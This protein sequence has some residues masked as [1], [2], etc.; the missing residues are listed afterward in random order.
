MSTTFLGPE[1]WPALTKAIRQCHAPCA[2]AVASFAQGAATLLPLSQGSRLVVD[3]SERA[4]ASGQTCPRDL[5]VLLR[6]GVTIYTVPNLHAKLFVLPRAAYVGSA[7]ASRHS[8]G[9]LLEALLRTTDPAAVRSA[10]EFVRSLCLHQ[11]T[12]TTLRTLSRLYRPPRVPGGGTRRKPPA[13]G[14]ATPDLPVLRLVQLRPKAWSEAQQQLH[15]K[16]LPQARDRRK[17]TRGYR[18]ESFIWS[19]KCAIARGE[20]LLQ[21]MAQ[22]AGRKTVSPPGEV[23]HTRSR[24][25]PSG[26]TTA[27]YVECPDQP[28]R[29]LSALTRQLG[30]AAKKRLNRSGVIRDQLLAQKLLNLWT[31]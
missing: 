26:Q 18:T 19:G 17:H 25:L 5:L 15:D 30:S 20:L 16:G 1:V 14:R 9:R 23:I 11:L 13:P 7:N 12:P 2:V 4:V 24:R 21:L 31:R 6:R 29:P 28:T 27:V 10:R 8:A 3:A 22:P